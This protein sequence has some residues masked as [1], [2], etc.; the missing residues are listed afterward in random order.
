[1]TMV[2]MQPNRNTF[3]F[4][5]ESLA[6]PIN[7]PMTMEAMPVTVYMTGSFSTGMPT[8]CTVKML[9][10]GISMKPPTVSRPVA[11]KPSR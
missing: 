1:M 9:T 4:P 11:A 7:G 3:S 8:L 6:R 5:N 2:T 10:K